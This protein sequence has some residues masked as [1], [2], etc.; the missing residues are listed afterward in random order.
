MRFS[1]ISAGTSASPLTAQATADW[2]SR[3]AG[4]GTVYLDRD[5]AS[6]WGGS[7]NVRVASGPT[8]VTAD[9][10]GFL[11]VDSLPD[12]GA[13]A[14]HTTL[15]NAMPV[16]YLSLTMCHS[17]DDVSEG[18][19]HELAETA[20]DFPCNRWNDAGDGWLYAHEIC[21]PDEARGY[22]IEDVLVSSF[23]TPS[24]FAPGANGP[25]SYLGSIGQ[26]DL[27]APFITG[28]AAYQVR[29]PTAGG[30]V[31]VF[32]DMAPHKIA[33]RRHWTSR[34]HRRGARL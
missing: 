17:L 28:P 6:L 26:A 15:G 14:E 27:S 21:D 34:T 12:P 30:D 32:G 5:V 3:V 29:R 23:V 2:L 20:A 22:R 16:C 18:I 33:K 10:I 1:I 11:L 19:A 25:Y 9:E 7:Y 8:D 31:Q 13:I 24:F 4:A